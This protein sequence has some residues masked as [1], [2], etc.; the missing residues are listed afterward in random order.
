MLLIGQT[1]TI[2]SRQQTPFS[3][4]ETSSRHFHDVDEMPSKS[5]G[6]H[7]VTVLP[8]FGVGPETIESTKRVLE[9]VEAPVAL[10]EIILHGNAKTPDFEDALTTIQRNKVALKVNFFVKEGKRHLNGYSN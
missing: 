9:A 4:S 8:G 1:L 10:E 2:Q 6:V 5:G 7:I 3:N